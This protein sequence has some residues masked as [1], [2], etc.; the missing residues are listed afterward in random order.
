[1]Q[2]IQAKGCTIT[3][4]ADSLRVA[5]RARAMTSS[6]PQVEALQHP[7]SRFGIVFDGGPGAG[8]AVERGLWPPVTGFSRTFSTSTRHRNKK[9]LRGS[10]RLYVVSA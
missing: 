8:G 3:S 5:N 6:M 4:T 10:M 2:A 9:R 1:V 7:V